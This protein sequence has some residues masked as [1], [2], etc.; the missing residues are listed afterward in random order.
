MGNKQSENDDFSKNPNFDINRHRQAMQQLSSNYAP[1]DINMDIDKPVNHQNRPSVEKA[2][3]KRVNRTCS[4][5]KPSFNIV[6]TIE[7]SMR[8]HRVL[9]SNSTT[10]ASRVANFRSMA[11]SPT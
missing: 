4:I 3:F 8:P 2:E 5:Y 1:V 11:E 7:F 10:I 9:I 6:N